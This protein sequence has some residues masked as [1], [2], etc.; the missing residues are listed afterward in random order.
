MRTLRNSLGLAGLLAV[1]L[2]SPAVAA[3]PAPV[4]TPRPAPIPDPVTSYVGHLIGSPN[5]QAAETDLG[6]ITGIRYVYANANQGIAISASAAG[7]SNLCYI[8]FNSLSMTTNRPGWT[9]SEPLET[10]REI[11]AA[12]RTPGGKILCV[13]PMQNSGAGSIS[14]V[15]FNG[16]FLWLVL[17]DQSSAEFQIILP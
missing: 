8:Q 12:A 4:P 11:V 17:G 6:V 9:R 1:A 7:K 16:T 3:G 15:T 5:S 13:A 10:Y 2:Q 14:R